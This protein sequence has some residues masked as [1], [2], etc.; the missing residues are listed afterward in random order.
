MSWGFTLI[1][2][3]SGLLGG[4]SA[5][6]IGIGG[7]TIYIFAIPIVLDFL[8]IPP[9][10]F[11]AYIVA[12]SLFAMFFASFSGNVVL[13][14]NKQFYTKQ[15]LLI[16]IPAILCALIALI[17]Y[18]NTPNYSRNIF[19]FIVIPIMVFMLVKTLV[20]TNSKNPLDKKDVSSPYKMVSIGTL[21][22]TLSSLTGLGGGVIMIPLMTNLLKMDIKK[23][24]AI[25]LGVIGF[26]T[27][28]MSVFNL[29]TNAPE[30][31]IPYSMGYILF[32]VVLP[33]TAGVIIGSPLGVK[34]KE[35]LSSKS[36]SYIYALFLLIVIVKKITEIDL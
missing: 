8:G 2:F 4:F 27:L 33:M 26:S 36:I 23:A 25:S 32:P 6:L 28:S 3:L 34:A 18:V 22:G 20:N 29:F 31:T 35:R 17:Y 12:N 19:N 16:S 9:D 13:I 15:V 21:G 5:G 1:L 11:A 7:G 10:N 30:V 14:K 24:G